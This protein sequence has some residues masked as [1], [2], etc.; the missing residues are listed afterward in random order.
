[1]WF[2]LAKGDFLAKESRSEAKIGQESACHADQN[3]QNGA[4]GSR[5]VRTMGRRRSF[6]HTGGANPDERAVESGQNT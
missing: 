3:V 2:D 4:L 1:V 5:K 6:A